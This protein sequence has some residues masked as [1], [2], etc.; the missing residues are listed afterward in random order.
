M[1]S[2]GFR[3]VLIHLMPEC[4]TGKGDQPLFIYG[5]KIREMKGGGNPRIR[6]CRQV[7]LY[8]T[9]GTECIDTP[10]ADGMSRLSSIDGEIAISLNQFFYLIGRELRLYA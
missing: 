7:L 1:R 2:F 3:L 6:G 5:T 8:R 9:D 10:A 4:F